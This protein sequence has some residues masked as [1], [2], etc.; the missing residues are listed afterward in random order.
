MVD[1]NN[2]KLAATFSILPGVSRVIII[3]KEQ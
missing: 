3:K 2:N 1:I